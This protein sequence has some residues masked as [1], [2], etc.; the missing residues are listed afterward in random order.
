MTDPLDTLLR[1]CSVQVLG[2]TQGSGFFVAPNLLVTCAHVVGKNRAIGDEK[3]IVTLSNGVQMPARLM[4]ILPEDDD[5]LALLEVR[6]SSDKC[7]LLG[8]DLSLNDQVLLVGFPVYDKRP[9]LDSLSARY[10]GLTTL[11]QE[12]N[13]RSF[14]K[15]KDA[16]VVEGF[17][18]GPLLNLRTGRVAGVIS[19]TRGGS[20]IGGWA[21]PTEFLTAR[22]SQVAQQNSA[23][24]TSH[25][26]LWNR[27]LDTRTELLERQELTK[28]PDLEL[29]ILPEDSQGL[30]RFYYGVRKLP[31]VG[32][33]QERAALELFINAVDSFQWCLL[34]GP[35]GL[36]KC[37]LALELCLDVI[38]KGWRGG[39][40]RDWNED[41]LRRWRPT[42]PTLI[43]A[44]YAAA[45]ANQLGRIV[46]QLHGAKAQYDFP[47]RLLILE[48]ANKGQWV[49]EFLGTGGDKY[50]VLA[51]QYAS[52]GLQRNL[53]P[54]DPGV[55]LSSLELSVPSDDELWALITHV[56]SSAG[57]PVPDLDSTMDRFRAIDPLR[58][59]LFVAL[60]ADAIIHGIDVPVWDRQTLID[61][62]LQREEEQFWAPAGVT[63]S[64]KD[65]LAFATLCGGCDLN[66]KVFPINFDA[67]Q[68]SAVR[69]HV[70]SG[71][72]AE[73]ELAPLEPDVVGELFTLNRLRPAH[74]LD[75]DRVSRMRETA[76]LHPKLGIFFFLLRA[77]S[78]FVDHPTL[79]HLARRPNVQFPAILL[80]W[81]EAT[82]ALVRGNCQ[83][84]KMAA[85][86]DLTQAL[87]LL[88]REHPEIPFFRFEEAV[89]IS[90]LVA[91]YCDARNLAKAADYYPSIVKLAAEHPN[92]G[93]LR[94]VQSEA[95]VNLIV[96][97][98]KARNLES[99][100]KFCSE[101]RQ[102]AADH[103]EDQVLAE[104]SAK[105]TF[106]LA[107]GF[108]VQDDPRIALNLYKELVNHS[109]PSFV[110]EYKVKT[111]VLLI[112]HMVN[113]DQLPAAKKLYEDLRK[114]CS[115]PLLRERQSAALLS[116]INKLGANGQLAEAAAFH[117]ELALLSRRSSAESILTARV[118]EAAANMNANC[119]IFGDFVL[120]EKFFDELV[121]LASTFA[122]RDTRLRLA[123]AAFNL[124]SGYAGKGKMNRASD[125]YRKLADHVS[126]YPR[127]HE[128]RLEQARTA[129][130]LID[131][132]ERT[133][134]ECTQLLSDLK[135]LSEGHTGEAL[136]RDE[137][138]NGTFIVA[139]KNCQAGIY[140]AAR[141]LY[142]DLKSLAEA[143]ANE[144]SLRVWQAR[145]MFNLITTYAKANDI[146]ACL[147]LNAE[148]QTLT[149]ACPNDPDVRAW[150]AKAIG[151]VLIICE[152]NERRKDA[153]RQYSILKGWDR[154]HPGEPALA[155]EVKRWQHLNR[156]AR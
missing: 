47:V 94:E 109:Y 18:G 32:R 96:A 3:V 86:S 31:Y 65:L 139:Q 147:R 17:S 76:W 72:S 100:G 85:V 146:E 117:R 107:V 73:T 106:N 29:P 142:D 28:Q 80:A 38:N 121:S 79:L 87:S 138:A 143:H 152:Q 104:R 50:S 129:V 134:A 75:T 102:M 10:E 43:V 19:M 119:V 42:R 155:E 12:R 6:H 74:V 24:T 49:E 8:N 84:G 132:Y 90:N 63:E 33:K 13:V 126:A 36:G 137:L 81:A 39:F 44:D 116:L 15:V 148:L 130:N 91:G 145:A 51:A 114:D 14:H 125:F 135:A 153:A 112:L 93:G 128:L 69:Y 60:F 20:S 37:R 1:E 11:Q 78:D 115:A 58:R 108:C 83:I 127:E 110:L 54:Y 68:F 16:H 71:H 156:Q 149:N 53:D 99:A 4:A 67:S 48:R 9:F 34:T 7:V 151:N 41:Q 92:E 140:E 105:G 57:Y 40:L 113:K 124:A 144:S 59:P 103:P 88:A 97:Y 5:D 56:F 55:I 118:A 82:V 27:A 122:T 64:E 45:R 154:S 98:A 111:A 46:R 77:S 141:S 150:G 25:A 22:F 131:G 123:K 21:I 95:A 133:Q 120:A 52:P 23:Y 101:V 2:E 35:G 66:Q 30:N 61:S 136:L 70:I 26:T 62:I 89:A